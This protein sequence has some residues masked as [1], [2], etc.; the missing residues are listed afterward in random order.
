MAV[1]TA[2]QH[3]PSARPSLRANGTLSLCRSSVMSES[4]VST[5]SR[6]A[7]PGAQCEL[8]GHL[9]V[10]SGRRKHALKLLYLLFFKKDFI[11]LFMRD[12]QREAETQAEGEAGSSGEP[13]AG[14]DPGTLGSHH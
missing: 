10:R 7:L 9:G 13:D 1:A 12:A 8:W 11:Y 4:G 5:R 3:P 2:A 14:L 6:S